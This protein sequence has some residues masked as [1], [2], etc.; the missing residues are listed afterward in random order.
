MTAK[1]MHHF[2]WV[3]C[4]HAKGRPST[5][6]LKYHRH[7]R[8]RDVKGYRWYTKSL[9][10]LYPCSSHALTNFFPAPQLLLLMLIQSI[11]SGGVKRSY[12]IDNS[13]GMPPKRHTNWRF[14]VQSP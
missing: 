12:I 10:M 3:N 1:I 14:G 6:S 8:L 4:P 7:N 5:I 11:L 13:T 9:L 2:F